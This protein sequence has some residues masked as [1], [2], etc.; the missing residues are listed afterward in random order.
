MTYLPFAVVLGL[1]LS[2][3]SDEV[4]L[5]SHLKGMIVNEV[6][7]MSTAFVRETDLKCGDPKFEI[8]WQ[9]VNTEVKETVG[10][11]YSEAL[12]CDGGSR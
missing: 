10:K 3:V 9:W 5:R 6:D 7:G 11:E 8:L 1:T 12:T 2:P 4:E